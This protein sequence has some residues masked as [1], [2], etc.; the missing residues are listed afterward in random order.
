MGLDLAIVGRRDIRFTKGDGTEGTEVQEISFSGVMNCNEQQTLQ[1]VKAP[2][3][4]K[5]YA[6][7]VRAQAE[8]FPETREIFAD[9]DDLCEREPIR[10]EEF[11]WADDHLKDLADWI[12]GAQARGFTVKFIAW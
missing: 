11:N 2:E 5:A 6:D 4:F 10:L 1:V 9:D 12:L 8:E 3:P 7:L